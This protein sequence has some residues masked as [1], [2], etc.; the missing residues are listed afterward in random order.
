MLACIHSADVAKVAKS[1]SK[2][3]LLYYKGVKMF[4][5]KTSTDVGMVPVIK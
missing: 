2:P 5:T 1:V 4:F 3:N